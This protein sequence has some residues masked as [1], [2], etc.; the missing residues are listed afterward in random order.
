[1]AD[2][3][4][5]TVTVD[6]DAEDLQTYERFQTALLRETGSPFRY[7]SVQPQATPRQPQPAAGPGLASATRETSSQ[8][9]E[10]SLRGDTGAGDVTH[11][12]S[13]GIGIWPPEAHYIWPSEPFSS[14]R[15]MKLDCWTRQIYDGLKPSFSIASGRRLSR[16]ISSATHRTL[17]PI[18]SFLTRIFRPQSPP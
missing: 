12:N 15:P 7:L 9:Q 18:S 1:V 17:R 11:N 5:L 6:L 3:Q 8:A 4:G 13:F 10:C 16:A 2:H 14:P